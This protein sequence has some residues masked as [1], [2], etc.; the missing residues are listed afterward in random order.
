MHYNKI[1]ILLL[2]FLL[3]SSSLYLW[4]TCN[5]FI[6]FLIFIGRLV[7]LENIRSLII[8][9]YTLNLLNSIFM[10][11]SV[12]TMDYNIIYHFWFF[13]IIIDRL[14]S[15]M[16]LLVIVVSFIVHIYSLSYMN[17]DSNII[18]F[19]SYLSLF[20]FF[21]VFLVTSNNLVQVFSGLLW[22]FNEVID[23]II[24]LYIY[25]IKQ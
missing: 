19:I 11:Y 18:R 16:I 22:C 20:T 12:W 2:G 4:W 7:G 10:F 13:E 9:F 14:S 3:S 24:I 5:L 6:F 8:F 1:Q 23:I 21:M 25:Q 17:G 15:F